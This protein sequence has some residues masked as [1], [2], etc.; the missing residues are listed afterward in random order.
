MIVYHHEEIDN[1]S[2]IL[3]FRCLLCKS[4]RILISLLIVPWLL[5]FKAPTLVPK[6]AIM[7][8]RV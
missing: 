4:F 6:V 5:V 1:S 7:Q 8:G 2:Q 3:V